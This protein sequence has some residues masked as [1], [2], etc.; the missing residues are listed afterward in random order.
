M[1]TESTASAKAEIELSRIFDAPVE[2]VWQ[3]WVKPELV[4]RWWGPDRFTCPSAEM[5][6]REGGSSVV[7]MRAPK[8]FK[9]GGDTYSI[10]NYRQ[11]KPYESIEFI[12]NLGTR[13]GKVL[14]PVDLGMPS[15]FPANVLTQVFFKSLPDGKTE[16]TIKEFGFTKSGMYEFAVMGL[17]Q[18]LNKMQVALGKN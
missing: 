11:I 2:Q 13:E 9:G 14:N 15:D 7:C 5:D 3:L 4:M 18:C 6:F 16:M 10:W 8:E 17:D 12:Q 1:P